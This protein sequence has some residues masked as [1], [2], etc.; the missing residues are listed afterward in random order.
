[1]SAVD[2][3]TLQKR[4]E[5]STKKLRDPAGYGETSVRNLQAAIEASKDRSLGRLLIGLNIPTGDIDSLKALEK[6][7]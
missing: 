3:F 1:M 7:A 6:Q 5:I 2:I 4:D